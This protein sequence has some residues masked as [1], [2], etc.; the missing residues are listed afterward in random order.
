MVAPTADAGMRPLVDAFR[1]PWPPARMAAVGLTALAFVALFHDPIRGL[2]SAWWNDPD[3]GHGLLLF[4]VALWLANKSG[5]REGSA[6]APIAGTILLVS[7]ILVR[8]LGGLAAEL[9]TQRFAIWL[10][11]V[12]LVVF[13]FGIR[14]VFHWWLPFILLGLAIPLPAT[15]TNTLA[16]PLQFK[17]SQLGT[18]LIDWRG[19]PVRANGN[20]ITI[21]G[22]RLFVAEACSGLRSLTALISLGVMMGG[23]WLTTLPMR[24][25]LILL[26]IPV[27]IAV[28][29]VRIFLTAFLMYFVSP[30]LGRGF[31]HTTEGW[32]LFVVALGIIGGIAAILG[33][34]ERGFARWRGRSHA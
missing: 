25:L 26:A 1:S 9:F 20:V 34:G 12:G 23:L 18:S 21:P 24:V 27:A 7:A 8:A 10:T 11:L 17:A 30:D 16:V 6:P 19:I 5:L 2:A 3:A 22:Q 14:Q 28:N 4:P 15:I 33:M 13:S 31:M 32:A 29:A